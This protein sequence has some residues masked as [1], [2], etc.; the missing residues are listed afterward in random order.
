MTAEDFT[1]YICD[2]EK[3]LFKGYKP[4]SREDVFKKCHLPAKCFDVNRHLILTSETGRQYL[5]R[6]EC[7]CTRGGKGFFKD[8][9]DHPDQ[10]KDRDGRFIPAV[11]GVFRHCAM[12]KAFNLNDEEDRKTVEKM[13]V[14]CLPLPPSLATCASAAACFSWVF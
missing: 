13:E 4:E 1:R 11:L 10:I 12:Y 8:D 9:H 14:S 3:G 5:Q 6:L 2:Y 7:R